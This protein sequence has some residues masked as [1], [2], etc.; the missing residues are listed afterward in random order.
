MKVWELTLI[1]INI[2]GFVFVTFFL[3]ENEE[4]LFIMISPIV[5][6]INFVS[7]YFGIGI[8]IHNAV[9]NPKHW[10]SFRQLL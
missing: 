5:Y 6:A 8:S 10:L 9:D 4:E 1:I 2:L 3:E 7:L